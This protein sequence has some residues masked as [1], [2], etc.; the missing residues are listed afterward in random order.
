MFVAA[1]SE[2]D[3]REA[4][5]FADRAGIRIVITGGLE[6]PL[7]APLLKE[8]NIPVIL[9]SVLTH[10]GARGRASCGD[11]QGRGRAGAGRRDVRVR[12]RRRGEQPPDSL[13]G[14][15]LGGV[16]PRSRPRAARDHA[17]CRDDP[18][19][20]RSRRLARARQDRQPVHRQR[21][22]DGD[23]D[24]VHARLHQRHGASGSRAN[25]P[26]STNASRRGRRV[27]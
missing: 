22:S 13:R 4:V 23:E 1:N 11:L 5:A 17:R 14:R 19:R 15:D 6:S 2:A 26:S 24:A 18:R 20:R 9:G 10:A 7:V 25:I 27:Q 8:K 21:R 16:G 3:I 12:H